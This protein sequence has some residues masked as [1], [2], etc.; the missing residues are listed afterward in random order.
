M[1]CRE[2]C[3]TCSAADVDVEFARG[4]CFQHFREARDL[5]ESCPSWRQA[6]DIELRR[7]EH[8]SIPLY[9]KTERR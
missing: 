3:A 9:E 4:F 6:H 5:E 7:R 8:L 1:S 2:I